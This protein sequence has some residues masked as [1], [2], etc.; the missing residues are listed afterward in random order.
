LV[1]D[2]TLKSPSYFTQGQGPLKIA[3]YH[4]KMI[5]HKND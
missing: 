3:M 4:T 5:S 1:S 2:S